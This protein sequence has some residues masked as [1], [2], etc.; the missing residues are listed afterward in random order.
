[1]A[2]GGNTT[3][4]DPS[5]SPMPIPRTRPRGRLEKPV[6][7]SRPRPVNLGNAAPRKKRARKICTVQRMTFTITGTP[8]LGMMVLH[9]ADGEERLRLNAATCLDCAPRT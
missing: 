9:D 3:P 2:A 8:Q 7:R 6:H 1:T 5:T 4:A